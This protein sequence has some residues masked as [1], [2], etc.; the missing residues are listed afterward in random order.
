MEFDFPIALQM[1]IAVFFLVLVRISGLF[2]ITPFFSGPAVPARM[3]V[4]LAGGIT[5][6]VAP[7]LWNQGESAMAMLQNPLSATIAVASEF[8]IGIVVGTLVAVV[9]GTIQTAGQLVAHDVGMTI[10]NIIDPLSNRQ[11]SIL[12]QLQTTVAIVVFLVLDFHHHLI[13]IMAGSFDLI[14]LGVF[15]QRSISFFG[16]QF[17]KVVEIEGSFVFRG[18]MQLAMPVTVTLVL[19]TVAMAFLARAVPEINVFILGFAIRIIVGFFVVIMMFPLLERI[20]DQLFD[21][22]IR[23]SWDLLKVLSGA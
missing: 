2:A 12:G 21:R 23:N 8:A 17:K 13:R 3:K 22:A 1:K 18:A 16:S 5:I 4:L 11:V 10:A 19:V 9:I 15:A 6:C 20:Y 14:P 7:L